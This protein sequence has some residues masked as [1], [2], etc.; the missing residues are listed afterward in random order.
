MLYLFI[1]NIIKI[2]L[3]Y[4]RIFTIKYNKINKQVSNPFRIYRILYSSDE[5]RPELRITILFNNI[6]ASL[7][8][9]PDLSPPLE[10]MKI[11]HILKIDSQLFGSFDGDS[12]APSS[13]NS[14][15]RHKSNRLYTNCNKKYIQLKLLV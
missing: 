14:S 8:T 1:T 13:G 6:L 2:Y 12:E 9:F 15:I 7:R 3:S 5:L 10:A 11:E 4:N